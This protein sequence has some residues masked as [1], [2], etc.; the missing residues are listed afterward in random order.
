MSDIFVGHPGQDLRQIVWGEKASLEAHLEGNAHIAWAMSSRD[1]LMHAE[2]AELGDVDEEANGRS[3]FTMRTRHVAAQLQGAFAGLAL[4]P[5]TAK[6][7]R[8][9]TVR[10]L[11]PGCLPSV[12]KPRVRYVTSGISCPFWD[13]LVFSFRVGDLVLWLIRV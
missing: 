11:G 7:S 9:S 12:Q 4:E 10:T 13:L 2:G 3:S 6:R 5:P 1:I 8:A